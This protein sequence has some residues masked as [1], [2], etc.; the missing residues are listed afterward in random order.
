MWKSELGRTTVCTDR[1]RASHERH[2]STAV[3]TGLVPGP[4]QP[5][6]STLLG[7]NRL[8]RKCRAAE[9]TRSARSRSGETVLP[10]QAQQHRSRGIDHRYPVDLHVADPV[11]Q[12]CHWVH[13]GPDWID[14]GHYWDR[15]DGTHQGPRAGYGDHRNHPQRAGVRDHSVV[16]NTLLGRHAWSQITA[17]VAVQRLAALIAALTGSD[18]GDPV[19]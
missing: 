19:S 12:K 9:P 16:T 4:Q 6:H 5:W 8:D 3:V 18:L 7:R 11:H 10:A 2:Q 14:P 17:N 1:E 13:P 15:H